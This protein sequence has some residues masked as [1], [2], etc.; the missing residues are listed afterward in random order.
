MHEYP[1]HIVAVMG[2][3]SDAA[4]R[5]LLVKTERRGWEPLGGQVEHG[6]DLLTALRREI[7]EESGCAVHVGRLESVYSNVAAP[8][9]GMLTFL[10]EHL[11]GDPRPSA[12]TSE[13]GWFDPVEARRLVTSPPRHAKL[14]DA[15]SGAPGVIYRAYRTAP[16]E[17]LSEHRF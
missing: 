8:E 3:V 4:G 10:C 14:L 5:V 12:E 13:A 1:R 2:V 16:Y 15:L 17:P 7:A 9:K 11:A 6:E